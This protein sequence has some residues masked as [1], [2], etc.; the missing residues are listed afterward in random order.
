MCVSTEQKIVIS[1]DLFFN[2][3]DNARE[4]EQMPENTGHDSYVKENRIAK[5]ENII[6]SAPG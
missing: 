1:Q 3:L 5:K 2:W 6:S 4:Q